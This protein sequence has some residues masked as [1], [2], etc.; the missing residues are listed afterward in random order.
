VSSDPAGGGA[1]PAAQ[2]RHYDTILAAYDEH[3]YE[4]HSR[5]YREEFILSPLLDGVELRG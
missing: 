5:R 1:A 4:V 2:A 3:Y